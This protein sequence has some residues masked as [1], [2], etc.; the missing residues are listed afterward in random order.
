[1]PLPITVTEVPLRNEILRIE[2]VE[3]HGHANFSARKFFKNAAGQWQPGPMGLAS[4]GSQGMP[5]N[6]FAMKPCAMIAVGQPA[7]A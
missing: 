4:K 1:M 6:P 5:C 2:V 7:E 3:L